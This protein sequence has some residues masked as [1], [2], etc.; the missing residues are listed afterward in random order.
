MPK[1][2]GVDHALQAAYS[3]AVEPNTGLTSMEACNPV[4]PDSYPVVGSGPPTLESG[5]APVMEFTVADIF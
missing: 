5:W 1:D 4:P 2:G 3:S